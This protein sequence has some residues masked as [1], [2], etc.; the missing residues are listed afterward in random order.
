MAQG[1]FTENVFK[2]RCTTCKGFNYYVHKNKKMVE[3]KL[4]LKK[5]CKTCR[6]ST[7]HKEAKLSAK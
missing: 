1:K 3:R 5:Y 2:F 7:I 4:E 6:K